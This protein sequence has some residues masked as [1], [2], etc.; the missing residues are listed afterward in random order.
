MV[1]FQIMLGDFLLYHSFPHIHR[2]YCRVC[3][4][5]QSD[6]LLLSVVLVRALWYLVI[7]LILFYHY[8]LMS[9]PD[10]SIDIWYIYLLLVVLFFRIFS[11]VSHIRNFISTFVWWNK[12]VIFLTSLRNVK[13]IIFLC[14]VV[15]GFWL[16]V[17]CCIDYYAGCYFASIRSWN[18]SVGMAT[19]YGLDDRGLGVQ[20]PVVSR[21][22]SSP[23]HPDR[24]WGIS[25]LLF[26]GHRGLFLR[27]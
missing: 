27:E 8:I 9:N 22:F 18:S 21:I 25:S 2:I 16:R 11:S 24:I 23:L 5:S 15:D 10:I 3:V 12:F 13:A 7:Y 14:S 19:G 20:V 1:S 4:L 17:C 6:T 26:N